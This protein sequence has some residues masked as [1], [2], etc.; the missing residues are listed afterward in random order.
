MKS[1]LATSIRCCFPRTNL[2]G[3]M[4]VSTLLTVIA[5]AT[6][7]AQSVPA[8]TSAEARKA[9]EA[10]YTEWAKARVT[11]DM[12]T[13]ERMLAPDFYF[14]LPDRKLT[15]QEFIDRMP[16]LKITRFDASVL[17][18]EPRGND[19]AAAISEKGEVETKDDHGKTSK[20]YIVLVARDGWRK[21]NDNQWT[22]LSSEPL[23]QQ[24]WQERPPIANW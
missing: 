20:G 23:G 21:L 15:R 24:R 4:L 19:W 3:H 17:T 12:N 2:G 9:I 1:R 7:G 22:L 6:A 11:L 8:V 10:G 14:Q 5:I 18:V 16:S 13:I